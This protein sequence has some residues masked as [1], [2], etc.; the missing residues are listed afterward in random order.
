MGP[1]EV[2]VAL[3]REQTNFRVS[4]LKD[5]LNLVTGLC[6]DPQA[7]KTAVSPF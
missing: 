6:C 4:S 5:Y 7:L 3:G 2:N 1:I